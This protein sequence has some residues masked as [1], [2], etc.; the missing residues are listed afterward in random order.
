MSSLTAPVEKGPK[1]GEVRYSMDGKI[2]KTV[3]VLAR[4]A[5][6]KRTLGEIFEDTVQKLLMK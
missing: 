4:F 5:V 3:P 6:E 2:L 1:V